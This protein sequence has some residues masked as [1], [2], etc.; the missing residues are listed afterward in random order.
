MDSTATNTNERPAGLAPAA[1]SRNALSASEHE[2]NHREI[3]S[4]ARQLARPLAEIAELYA[5]V[6]ADLKSRARVVDYLPVLVA[7]RVRE[8]C[9]VDYPAID[10]RSNRH[11]GS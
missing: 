1:R 4:I 7:R 3:E 9:S 10:Q 2:R 8:C 11:P 5:A 6:Y